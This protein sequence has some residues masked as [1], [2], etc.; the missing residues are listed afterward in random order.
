[1]DLGDSLFVEA[2]AD[3]ASWNTYQPAWQQRYIGRAAPMSD[4]LRSL[5]SSVMMDIAWSLFE[6]R[7]LRDPL[8]DPN[9]L[10]TEI[11]SRYLQIVPHPEWSW[12]AV[13]GQLVD[14]P[15]YMINYGLGAML[16]ADLRRHIRDLLGPFET[17]DARWY[18]WVSSRLLRFGLERETPD[19]LREFLGR[20]VSSK[21]LLDDLELLASR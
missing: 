16:T 3:V 20:P 6:I 19:L 7:M 1:M 12:W 4:S 14:S 5:Y 8:A 9:K 11:T 17:G 18:P 2:F 21:A 13:R 15:G 10:W